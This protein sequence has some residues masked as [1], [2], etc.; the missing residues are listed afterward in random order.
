MQILNSLSAVL[1]RLP[2]VGSKNAK[3]MAYTLLEESKL[4]VQLMDALHRLN[5]EVY[6]CPTCGAYT[7]SNECPYCIGYR[8][9]P[10]I[11]CIVEK[12]SDVMAI[13]SSG[14]FKGLYHVLGG[15]LSPMDG[16]GPQQLRLDSLRRRLDEKNITEVVIATN[17]NLEGDATA[18]Y[19]EQ[20]L[21]NYS[22]EV[23]R[24]AS[25]LSAGTSLEY[26]DR[27]SLASSLEGRRKV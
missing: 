20:W 15:A 10:Y 7:Q 19:L 14:V 23:T 17:L 5:D 27:E 25:G 8:E 12:N 21:K 2:G 13:E 3:R 9:Q 16:I 1:S 24:I 26:A 18:I 22:L 4:R 11:L 6:T